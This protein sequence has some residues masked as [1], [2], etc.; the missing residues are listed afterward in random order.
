[1]T[2]VFRQ[3]MKDISLE[4]NEAW[5]ASASGVKAMVM[6]PRAGCQPEYRH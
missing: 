1:M 6:V 3:R 5:L 4:R 2:R